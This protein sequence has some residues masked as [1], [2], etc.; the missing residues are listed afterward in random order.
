MVIVMRAH[1]GQTAAEYLGVLFFVLAL[2]LVFASTD[3]P[4]R[5]AHAVGREICLTINREKDC[6]KPPPAPP[7]RRR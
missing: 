7:A 6:D 1:R 5:V 3:F 2:I 4:G